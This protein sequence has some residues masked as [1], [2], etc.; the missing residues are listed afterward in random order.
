MKTCPTCGTYYPDKLSCP[1]C[2]VEVAAKEHNAEVDEVNPH[3]VNR[4]NDDILQRYI[5]TAVAQLDHLDPIMGYDLQFVCAVRPVDGGMLT[6]LYNDALERCNEW[7]SGAT[8]RMGWN[9]VLD[10]M[11]EISKH[12]QKGGV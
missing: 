8:I 11:A 6:K 10:C 3:K 2:R 1:R 5:D 7:A 9:N 12:S 4:L